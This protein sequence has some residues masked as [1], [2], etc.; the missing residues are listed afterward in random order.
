MKFLND[1]RYFQ[2]SLLRH[3]CLFIE[4]CIAACPNNL[5][6]SI[7][8]LIVMLLNISMN[9]QGVTYESF[10]SFIFFQMLF[11]GFFYVFFSREH[12]PEILVTYSIFISP[13]TRK[14][15]LESQEYLLESDYE[16]LNHLIVFLCSLLFS[17]LASSH[18]ILSNLFT[19]LIIS[20]SIY[21]FL[22][23]VTVKNDFQNNLMYLLYV[24]LIIF[25]I[26]KLARRYIWP[27]LYSFVASF[28]AFYCLLLLFP[29]IFTVGFWNTS[30]SE[31]FNIGMCFFMFVGIAV[32]FL[33]QIVFHCK[34][35]I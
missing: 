1:L 29:D 21:L 14:F 8:S 25:S 27:F 12:L 3:N 17:T 6:K 32:Q 2:T 9:M 26:L 20:P 35:K 15:M 16:Y 24:S 34:T 11:Q 13:E 7:I 4:K 5:C 18:N 22:V 19:S 30:N 10:Y 33:N 28:M 31:A 23:P